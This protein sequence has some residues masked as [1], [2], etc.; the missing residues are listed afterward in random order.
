MLLKEFQESGA[1]YDGVY[2]FNY[3]NWSEAALAKDKSGLSFAEKVQLAIK[4]EVD[5]II[6]TPGM[7]DTPLILENSWV[8]LITQYKSIMIAAMVRQTLP[9]LQ[10]GVDK[11]KLAGLLVAVTGAFVSN[12]IKAYSRDE[13]FDDTSWEKHLYDALEGTANLSTVGETVNALDLIF[14][15]NPMILGPTGTIPSD[16]MKVQNG[17]SKEDGMN[18]YERRAAIRMLPYGN[19]IQFVGGLTGNVI[20]DITTQYD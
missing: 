12:Q 1:S 20:D 2:L 13:E 5:T 8:S 4:K 7:G 3:E 11:N 14:N 18:D 17:L 19:L 16:I 9:L 15:G 6:T 10:N